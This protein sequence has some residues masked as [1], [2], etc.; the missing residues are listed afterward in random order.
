MPGFPW[1]FRTLFKPSN[2][3]VAFGGVQ[4]PSRGA[5]LEF[6]PVL[7]KRAFVPNSLLIL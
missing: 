6:R 5:G 7:L 1:K 4:R 2:E 3:A